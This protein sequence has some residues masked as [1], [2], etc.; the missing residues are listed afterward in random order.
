MIRRLSLQNGM[1]DHLIT[2]ATRSMQQVRSVVFFTSAI[3]LI[4][5]LRSFQVLRVLDLQGCDLSQS[6]GL[7]YVGNLFHLRYLGLQNARIAHIPKEIGNLQ[8]LQLL[9]ARSSVVSCLPSSIIQLKYLMCLYTNCSTRVP[10][11]IGRLTNLEELSVLYIDG[12]N[13]DIIEELGQLMELRVLQIFLFNGWNDKLPQGLQKLQNIQELHIMTSGQCRNIGGL[14]DWVAPRHLR[15]LETR[16]YSCFSVLPSWMHP[17]HVPDL[18]SLSIAV[19]ELRQADLNILGR[20]PV[21]RSLKLKVDHKS[22]RILEGFVVAAGSFQWLVYCELWGFVTPVAFQQ[23][24]M[25]R[26]R[27]FTFG[28]L[29]K[30]A[31]E[32]S[33]RCGGGLELGLGNLA[34]LQMVTVYLDSE[35][36]SDEEVKELKAVLG[37]ATKNHPNHPRHYILD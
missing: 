25:P 9:D 24:A 10:N 35:A 14:D 33:S 18:S 13:E 11:G 6:G 4:P 7:K 27:S 5:V 32:I 36:A 17:S 3:S 21:L 20:L 19:R 15:T 28:F 29:V 30:V 1:E 37:H 16:S 31:R 12:S 26:L 23:G 8:F 2:L 22:L 34:C